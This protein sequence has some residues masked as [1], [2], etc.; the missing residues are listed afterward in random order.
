MLNEKGSQK[1]KHRI[2]TTMIKVLICDD[3]KAFAEKIENMIQ[4]YYRN[5]ELEVATTVC[6]SAEEVLELNQLLEYDMAFLDAKMKP[7]D[8]IELGRKLKSKNSAIILIYISAFLEFALQGYRVDTFRFLLKK[9]VR[10]DLP[11]CLEEALQKFT[12]S[13]AFF[14]YKNR[15]ESICIPLKDIY[16]FESDL[17]KINIYGIEPNTMI[18][19]F[20]CRFSDLANELEFSQ[21]LQIGKSD[22]VNMAYIK[23]IASY[24]VVLTNGVEKGVSRKDYQNIKKR[25]VEWKGAL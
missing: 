18:G 6:Q 15:S 10:T 22:L 19:S 7:V 20:N 23:R 24:R 17:R 2:G 21:F 4:N 25:F 13:N 16:Y 9:D 1:Y 11:I 14:E 5:K 8:G 3:D 12:E